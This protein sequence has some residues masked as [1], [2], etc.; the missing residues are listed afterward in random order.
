MKEFDCAE[1]TP[2]QSLFV[3]AQHYPPSSVFQTPRNH[4][5]AISSPV[6]SHLDAIT[7]DLSVRRTPALQLSLGIKESDLDTSWESSME[8]PM[9][10]GDEA[11]L[12]DTPTNINTTSEVRFYCL[13]HQV[14]G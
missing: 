13:D 7:P 14:D 8:T 10:S 6:V 3:A 1:D 11:S 5:A 2:R 9:K 4:H 12:I